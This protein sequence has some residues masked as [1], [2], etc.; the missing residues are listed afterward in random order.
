M[1][2]F[3]KPILMMALAIVLS[4][5]VERL[6]ELLRAIEDFLEARRGSVNKWQRVAEQLRD[7]IEVRLELAKTAG[8]STL[9]RLLTLAARYLSAAPAGSDGLF[10]IS[11]DKVRTLTIQFACKLYA[12]VLGIGLAFV[13]RLDLFAL[14]N[15]S[16][17][18]SDGYQIVLPVWLGTLLSGIALGFGAGPVHKLIVALERAR[19]TRR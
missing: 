12:V 8:Q 6:L 14:V 10:A 16:I 1:D 13:F 9:H 18:Q 3:E 17:H 7:R 19:D 2:V 4:L 11:T 5:G 15:A